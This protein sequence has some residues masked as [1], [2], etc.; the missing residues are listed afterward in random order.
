MFSFRDCIFYLFSSCVFVSPG[1]NTLYIY[2]AVCN[3]TA[4][5]IFF[6][7]LFLLGR[8]LYRYAAVSNQTAFDFFFDQ[9]QCCRLSRRMFARDRDAYSTNRFCPKSKKMI[10]MVAVNV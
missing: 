10:T 6:L 1:T 3:Q 5:S 9:C 8:T 4:F 7:C 2:A